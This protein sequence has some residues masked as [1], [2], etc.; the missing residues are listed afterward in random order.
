M[1]VFYVR[2]SDNGDYGIEDAL[3]TLAAPPEEVDVALFRGLRVPLEPLSFDPAERGFASLHRYDVVILAGLDPVVLTPSECL[4]LVAFVERGGGLMLLGGSHSFSNAEGTYHLLSP[5]L[6]VEVRRWLD[7]EVNGLPHATG[8]P[9]AR[10]LPEPAGYVVKVHPVE[11]KP[12]AQVVMTAGEFPFVVA[13]EYGY[14]RVVVVASY[15]ECQ[16]SEYGW[17]FTGDA[18]NDF[19]RGAVAWMMKEHPLAWVE[20]FSLPN[21]EPA[22]G[23]E[24]FGKLLLNSATPMEVRVTTRLVREKGEVVLD[25]SAALRIEGRHEVLF[26]FRVPEGPQARGVHHV[27]VLVSDAEGRELVRRDVAVEVVNPVR[28][29]LE[30]EYGRR[31][32]LPGGSARLRVHVAKSR[33]AALGEAT[34][35]VA[36]LDETG[37][38][39]SAAPPRSL[40]GKEPAPWMVEAEL[41]VPDLHPGAYRVRAELRGSAEAID[42]ASEDVFVLARPAAAERFPLIAEGGYHLDRPTVERAIERL[43]AAGVTALSLPGPVVHPWEQRPHGEAMLGY[44]EEQAARHG[45]SIAHHHRSLVP[46]QTAAAPLNPCPLTP[47]FREATESHIRPILTGAARVPGLLFHEIVAQAAVTPERICRCGACEAAFR[48][49]VGAG[50]PVG[51]GTDPAHGKPAQRRALDAFVA[52]YW[53]R[54]YAAIQKARD[55]APGRVALCLPLGVSS[56]L[57]E[58]QDHSACDAARWAQACDIVDVAAEPDNATFRLSLS[59]H[60]ALCGALG[61]TFGAAIDIAQPAPAEAAY[62]ALAHGAAHLRIA[63]NPR[64][65]FWRRQPTLEAAVGRCFRRIAKAGP[66]LAAS[67]R[68]RARVALLFPFTQAVERGSAQLLAAH[69]LLWSALGDVDLLHERLATA[70]GLSEYAAV[71]LLATEM[72]PRRA[73]QALID[74]VDAG[75]LLLA[76]RADLRHEDGAAVEWPASFFGEAETPVFGA[77]TRRRRAFGAGR[78]ILFSDDLASAYGRANEQE[79]TLAV[80]ALRQAVA[81]LLGEQGIRPRARAEDPAVEVGIRLGAETALLVAVNHSDEPRATSVALDSAAIPAAFAFDLTTGEAVPVEPGGLPA[82]R[83]ALPPRDGGI[84]VLYPERPFSLRVELAQ[85]SFR[86]GESLLYRALVVGESGQPARGSHIVHVTV[87]DP[88]GLERPDLGGPYATRGGLLDIARPLAANDPT[89][90]WTLSVT[91]PLTRRVVRRTFGLTA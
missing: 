81:D 62:T 82:L 24:S 46:G 44:A 19:L 39:R 20:A 50:M 7:V 18:F 90:T 10:G 29:S 74:Y 23:T 30:F 83:I 66:L 15:P 91:D 16:E 38:R 89:G 88:G 54:V 63:E 43:G 26:S 9:I 67:K 72:L 41:P 37:A 87:T 61:K 6:P 13:G 33:G 11:A 31:S 79:D 77:L 14:G 68:P 25:H 1:R 52:S 57:R 3:A 45:L 4:A 80:R 73:T 47:S 59:G 40:S 22:P 58:A 75:G 85:G 27:V 48:R 76:D 21:R 42:A 2:P 69:E 36:L 84:W 55:Q 12:G 51:T 34:L 53:S 5:I 65:L 86:R 71:A 32:F 56:F 17:F 28:V 8:H 49:K 35:E 64:F 78:T 70:D 60:R